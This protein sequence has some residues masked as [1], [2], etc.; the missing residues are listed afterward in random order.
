MNNKSKGFTLVELSIV[1]IIIGFL[2]AGIAAGQSLIKQA[3]FNS[4]ISDMQGFQASYNNFVSRYGEV[5]GDMTDAE[6]YWP[7]G[8][9]TPCAATANLCNG[10]GNGLISFPE[11]GAAWKELALAGMISGNIV[12]LPADWG[13]SWVEVPGVT[14]P[15]SK[16]DGGGYTMIGACHGTFGCTEGNIGNGPWSS[17]TPWIDDATNAVFVAKPS[18]SDGLG[19]EVFTSADAFSIDQKIDDG[20]IDSGGNFIGANTGKFQSTNGSGQAIFSGSCTVGSL[21]GGNLNIY[22]LT[23]TDVTCVSGWALN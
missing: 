13:L 12:P 18:T 11:T 9:A 1:I 10:D 7:T 16:I 8:G 19:A 22:K 15:V 2:I 3:K 21:F 4:V 20:Q 23:N 6:S 5:P 17:S 14:T